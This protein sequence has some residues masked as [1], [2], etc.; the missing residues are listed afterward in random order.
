MLEIKFKKYDYILY[1]T[2]N[3]ISYYLFKNKI[4]IKMPS[5][6][7]SLLSLRSSSSC[8]YSSRI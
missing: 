6:E 1:T 3:L 2:Y 8:S 4:K 5:I 7:L